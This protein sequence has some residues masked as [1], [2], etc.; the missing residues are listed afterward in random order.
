M[1]RPVFGLV[2][3]LIDSKVRACSSEMPES[4]CDCLTAI[5]RYSAITSASS[6]LMTSSLASR[7]NP[8]FL[9][10]AI[11]NLQESVLSTVGFSSTQWD[12]PILTAKMLRLLSPSQSDT[13]FRKLDRLLSPISVSKRDL[14]LSN[15]S[16]CLCSTSSSVSSG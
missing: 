2:E 10:V 13:I 6:S 9:P 12:A 1:Q 16:W 4:C 11:H 3:S 5:D 15:C 7:T 8:D 14:S